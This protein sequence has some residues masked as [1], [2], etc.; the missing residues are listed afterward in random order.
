VLQVAFVDIFSKLGTFRFESA[1]GLDQTGCS[2]QLYQPLAP[3]S[4]DAGGTR[5][6]L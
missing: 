1:V 4:A 3:T 2:Q 5:P 6:P